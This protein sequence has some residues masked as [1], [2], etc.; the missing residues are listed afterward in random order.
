MKTSNTTF[1]NRSNAGI[2]TISAFRS[3]T[4]AITTVPLPDVM[5]SVHVR[6]LRGDTS[7]K[8][9]RLHLAGQMHT[10]NHGTV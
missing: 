2:S 4:D 1:F 8:K 5:Q 6:Q 10:L 7:F 9:K 3:E